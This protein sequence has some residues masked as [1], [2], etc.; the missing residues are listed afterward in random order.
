MLRIETLARRAWQLKQQGY[1]ILD[2]ADVIGR[3]TSA[4]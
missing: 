3:S 2:I 1:S 4:V